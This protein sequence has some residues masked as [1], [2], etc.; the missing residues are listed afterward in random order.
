MS[1]R[2]DISSSGNVD[3]GNV[4]LRVLNVSLIIEGFHIIKKQHLYFSVYMFWI[5]LL[6]TVV[7]TAMSINN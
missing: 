1:L 6:L 5:K 2:V 3:F 7:Y 4:G